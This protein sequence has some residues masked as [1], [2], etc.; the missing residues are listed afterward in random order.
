MCKGLPPTWDHDR[1]IHLQPWSV[2]PNIRPY[3]YPYAQKSEIENMVQ[4]MLDVSII[5]HKQISFSH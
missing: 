2:S 3:M 5:Q 4:E 1:A